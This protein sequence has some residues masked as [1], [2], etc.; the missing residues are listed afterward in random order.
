MTVSEIFLIIYVAVLGCIGVIGANR[1]SKMRER[2]EKKV[3]ASSTN[4]LKRLRIAVVRFHAKN[5][6]SSSEIFEARLGD[7]EAF[8]NGFTIISSPSDSFF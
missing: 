3:S 6:E 5:D 1:I 8:W 4:P 7:S 2:E